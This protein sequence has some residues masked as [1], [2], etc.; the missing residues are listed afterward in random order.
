V[1]LAPLLGCRSG[2]TPAPTLTASPEARPADARTGADTPTVRAVDAPTMPVCTAT[3][4]LVAAPLAES[5]PATPSLARGPSGGLVAF[6][7][8]PDNGTDPVVATLSLNAEGSPT[9]EAGALRDPRIV[10]ETGA[11]PSGPA[12]AAMREGYVLVWRHG[13]A[14]QHALSLRTLDATG[15]P[16]TPSAVALLP[17]RGVMGPPAV[18]VDGLGARWVAVAQATGAEA[19]GSAGSL[20]AERIIVVAPDGTP[21]AIVAPP[22][23]V[24]EGDAPVLVPRPEGGVRVYVTLGAR[25]ATAEAER[26]LVRVDGDAIELVARDLDRP[27]AMPGSTPGEV[28]FAWR[29]RMARRDAALRAATVADDLSPLHSPLSLATFRGAYDLRPHWITLGTQRAVLALSLLGDEPV[30]ALTLSFL[31]AQGVPGGRAAELTSFAARSGRLAVAS[32]PAGAS[33]PSAW[34][35][36]DGRD[37]TR[38]RLL[39]TRVRCDAGRAVEPL[40]I[41]QGAFVQE[42]SPG[43]PAPAQLARGDGAAGACTVRQSGVVTTHLS[44]VDDDPLQ[45]TAALVVN[46]ASDA[47]IFVL[48]RS[49]GATRS[50]LSTTT[51]SLRGALGPLRPVVEGAGALLA[52]G[53]VPGGA[54]AV[55]TSRVQDTDRLDLVFARGAAVNHQVLSTGLRNPRSAVVEPGGAVLAVGD[56][57]QGRAVLV[58]VATTAGRAGAVTTLA[59]LR[60]GDVVRDAVRQGDAVRVLLGRTDTLGAEVSQA[61]VVLTVRDGAVARVVDPFADPAGFPRGL[62]VLTRAGGAA[63]GLGVM[64]TEGSSVRI[65]ALDGSRMRGGANLLDAFPGGGRI[66]GHSR[67][68][69]T[70][71]VALATG[72]TGESASARAVTLARLEGGAVRALSVRTPDDA[73][74][75]AEAT[76]LAADGDRVVMV[77]PRPSPDT[78]HALNWNWLD[79]TCPAGASR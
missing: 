38:P 32:A 39:V 42:V 4:A 69:G 1:A 3:D 40:D 8:R 11:Q 29:A 74:A 15:A 10:P 5:L 35:A 37:G 34:V 72:A 16:S 47:R 57:D 25:G 52:A 48:A 46:T 28:L 64:H 23:G 68:G 7:S 70:H 71:W 54:V 56:D 9:D 59:T 45:G 31:G 65:T 2:P 75:L 58:R 6:V 67:A 26:N 44:G 27:T 76:A 73:S 77:Y 55:A 78:H 33:D 24:F 63:D 79:V 36:V 22:G 60:P 19:P 17:A 13:V 53:A 51:L 41:P 21:R 50:R 20:W 12:L 62:A 18:A 30:G 43:E 49:T 66:L 61:V 14:G